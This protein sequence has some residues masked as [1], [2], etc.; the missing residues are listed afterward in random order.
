MIAIFGG[1]FDPVHLGHL[2]MAQQCA[3]PPIR[4]PEVNETLDQDQLNKYSGISIHDI[5]RAALKG[6][7]TR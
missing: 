5:Q 4:L 2:N 7:T 6:T 3:H 1:T